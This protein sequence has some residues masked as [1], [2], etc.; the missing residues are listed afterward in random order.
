MKRVPF[1]LARHNLSAL[2][3]RAGREGVVITRQ[4][5]PAGVLIGFA[6]E[7]DW[8]DFRLESDPRFLGRIA[9][10]RRSVDAGRFRSLENLDVGRRSAVRR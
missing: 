9:Q 4:G 2:L 7:N 1:G 8:H 10:S 6:T 5:K 3:R